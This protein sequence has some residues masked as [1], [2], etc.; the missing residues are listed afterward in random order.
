LQFRI[1]QWCRCSLIDGTHQ[2]RVIFT[3]HLTASQS[4]RPS[5]Q[6]GVEPLWDSWT[7]FGCS[8]DSCGFVVGRSPCWEDGSIL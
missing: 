3:F 1:P 5:V 7:D 6:I 8:Q 2:V 4:V